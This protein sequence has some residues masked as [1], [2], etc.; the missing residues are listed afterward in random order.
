MRFAAPPTGGRDK[1]A[2]YFASSVD[3]LFEYSLSDLNA[4]DMVV[5]LVHN[6]E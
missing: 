3:K 1:L 6:E 2:R 4:G 5:I